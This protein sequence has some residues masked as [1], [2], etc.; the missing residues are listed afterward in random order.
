MT[1]EV[2]FNGRLNRFIHCCVAFGSTVGKIDRFTSKWNRKVA[3]RSLSGF[4]ILIILFFDTNRMSGDS[5]STTKKNVVFITRTCP[6]HF[7]SLLW[8]KSLLLSGW[9]ILHQR[10]FI[11]FFTKKKQQKKK[12]WRDYNSLNLSCGGEWANDALGAQ[13]CKLCCLVAAS[14]PTGTVSIL[15]WISSKAVREGGIN[16]SSHAVHLYLCC[17]MHDS[18][19]YT[20]ETNNNHNNNIKT[21]KGIC[22]WMTSYISLYVESEIW[23][24]HPLETFKYPEKPGK[25]HL[26]HVLSGR[27]PK[28][29]SRVTKNDTGGRSPPARC[30]SAFISVP[31]ASWD[32]P[33]IQWC[34]CVTVET[35]WEESGHL[36]S[37]RSCHVKLQT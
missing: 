34:G 7:G 3:W 37:L 18:S 9:L 12:Q 35:T 1:D 2:A 30:R 5:V 20:K 19:T 31:R 10:L 26:V 23:C 6:E 32:V 25:I 29:V 17:M 27:C 24:Q 21:A 33:L 8:P 16:T 4:S 28:K 14:H 13:T 15:I 22:Q 11:R 36:L